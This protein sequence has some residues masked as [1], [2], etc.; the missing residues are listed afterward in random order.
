M[1]Y[2]ELATKK[3]FIVNK[4]LGSALEVEPEE[5][6]TT[7]ADGLPIIL[8]TQKQKYDFDRKGWL[9][10]PDVLSEQEI[11]EI[12]TFCKEIKNND[13][14]I[15]EPQICGL[16]G[17][18]QKLADH[19]V[20]VGLL[21]EF[22]A[23]PP[24]ASEECYGFRLEKSDVQL[25]FKK[26]EKHKDKENNAGNGL[27]RLPGDSHIYR[28][29]PGR[30]WSGLTRIIW[31]L[32]EVNTKSNDIRFITASH[33]SAYV[34]PQTIHNN[35]TQMWET[36]D[37]PPGSLILL[38]ESITQKYVTISTD[39]NVD[40]LRITNLYNTIASRWCNWLPSPKLID[41]MPPKR[42]SLFRE[43][44]AGGNVVKGHFGDRTSPYPINI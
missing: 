2:N 21:N 42:Q 32:S 17:P 26:V 5:L 37:C 7:N 6:T 19:P 13:P 1:E 20:V 14:D 16:E 40:R 43:T 22:L 25:G 3:P 34:V 18:M 24:T 44:F 11:S 35:N 10:V 39:Q 28:C 33:K 23:Y 9:L 36:Y 27:F 4:N 29:V 15:T 12:Q 31:E 38:T 41:S 8:P 30:A